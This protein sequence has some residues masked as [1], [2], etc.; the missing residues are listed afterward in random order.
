MNKL[1]AYVTLA[2]T[3]ACGSGETRKVT[4][5]DTD[6]DCL[7]ERV[8][9]E[10]SCEDPIPTSGHVNDDSK[11]KIAFAARTSEGI[12]MYIFDLDTES[13]SNLGIAGSCPTLSPDDTKVGYRKD[14]AGDIMLVDL[15]SGISTNLTKEDFPMGYSCP[16]WSP[17]GT[18]LVFHYDWNGIRDIYTIGADGDNSN[19]LGL[20]DISASSPSWS[21][22]GRK[23]VFT[24]YYDE[25]CERIYTVND[26]G[27][28]VTKITNN[29][30]DCDFQTTPDDAFP[31]WSPDGTKIAFVSSLDGKS[32]IYSVNV[33][34]TGR[35]R[36][37][38]NLENNGSPTWSPNSGRI[39]FNS[40]KDGISRIYLI[41][42]DGS[43]Q[44][45]LFEE[46]QF[47]E[48]YTP[49]WTR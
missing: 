1:L 6:N 26:T 24:G 18:K 17:D 40:H 25:L 13:L 5:C 10:G 30:G 2:L 46:S 33:D 8:C 43:N 42:V 15:D 49:S 21:P 31:S 35:R 23:I 44:S 32:D 11:G 28:N 41:G 36:I 27:S 48:E 19:K 39:A 12:D 47:I 9:V 20:D 38:R 45:K 7:E 22:N 4:P 16:S 29:H 34:G 37:T 14:D 3:M